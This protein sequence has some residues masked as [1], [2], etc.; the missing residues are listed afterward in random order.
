MAEDD[1]FLSGGKGF[2]NLTAADLPKPFLKI[3]QKTSNEVDKDKPEFIPSLE[4]GQIFNSLTKEILGVSFV[5]VV[6]HWDHFWIEYQA[7]ERGPFVGFRPIDSMDL[8]TS[9]YS[10]WKIV[11]PRKTAGTPGNVIVDTY[12]LYLLVEGKED[13]GIMIA[14]FSGTGIQDIKS[15]LADANMAKTSKGGKA[16]IIAFKYLFEAK[17]NENKSGAWWRYG[18]GKASSIAPKE[19]L[20]KEYFVNFV[21]G[22]LAIA[23]TLQPVAPLVNT[24]SVAVRS[25]M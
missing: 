1:D 13:Q 12:N 19:E 15:F 2:D 4:P 3:A 21:K 24:T 8:D 20:T 22:P 9:D 5:G 25:D 23:E 16:N 17:R 7:G 14:A 11:N 18:A 6:L 10:K